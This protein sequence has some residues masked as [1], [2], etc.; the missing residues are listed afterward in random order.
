[1]LRHL[2]ERHEVTLVSFVR[3]DDQPE[4]ISHLREVCR[5]V[6]T[7]PIRRSAWR[8][9]RAGAKGLVTGLPV[10]ISRDEMAEMF[11]LLRELADEQRFDVIHADQLSMAGY[12]QYGARVAE[13][14]RARG[15][16]RYSTSTMRS[17]C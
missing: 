11:G 13:R 14:G 10:V 12:G 9:V 4:A 3:A 7:V 1:M 2:A 6:H 17:T 5:E 15:R 16:R 8:N